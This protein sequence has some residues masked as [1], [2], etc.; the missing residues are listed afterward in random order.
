[1]FFNINKGEPF[2]E[3]ATISDTS[4]HVCWRADD[5]VFFDDGDGLLCSVVMD[6]DYLERF[7][8]FLEEAAISPDY[9]E[10]GIRTVDD[11]LVALEEADYA[12]TR[13]LCIIDR[14][15]YLT[16]VIPTSSLVPFANFLRDNK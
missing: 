12:G 14:R 7:C 5:N 10:M 11:A 9:I 4:S 2:P 15:V 16:L 13:N 3:G 6:D 8:V 1:M